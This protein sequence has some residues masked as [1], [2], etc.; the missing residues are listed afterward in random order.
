MG[1]LALISAIDRQVII[2]GTGIRLERMTTDDA[3]QEPTVVVVVG[4]WRL[5]PAVILS[6][7]VEDISAEREMKY[8]K[9]AIAI[10][11]GLY[12]SSANADWQ[13]TKWGMTVEQARE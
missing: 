9:I 1:R 3:N 11:V 6:D 13:Y 7:A 12:T 10:C 2:P 8:H 5:S 4:L